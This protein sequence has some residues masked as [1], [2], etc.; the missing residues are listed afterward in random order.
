[1]GRGNNH[2]NISL[3][4]E[5]IME[6]ID[7]LKVFDKAYKSIFISTGNPYRSDD[8][9]GPYISSKL[10]PYIPYI[11]LINAETKPENYIDKVISLLPDFVIFIDAADFGEKPGEFILLDDEKELQKNS[12]STHTLP[13]ALV[14]A[15]IKSECNCS[16]IY[17]G[18][19]VKELGFGEK[20]TNSVIIAADMFIQCMT[21]RIG[22]LRDA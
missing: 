4:L 22:R 10:T 11:Y 9:V 15:M 6:R 1:M 20:I 17:I 13:L 19:Q 21:D 2:K 5:K 3:S 18:I 12:L 7:S 14:T 16:I 8:G